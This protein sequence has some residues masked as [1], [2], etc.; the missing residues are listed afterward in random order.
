[1]LLFHGRRLVKETE[2]KP[3]RPRGVLKADGEL[4][5]GPDGGHV[6]RGGIYRS[7]GKEEKHNGLLSEGQTAGE[8]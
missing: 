8:L 3:V 4:H 6:L 2:L 1:M 5:D 7:K